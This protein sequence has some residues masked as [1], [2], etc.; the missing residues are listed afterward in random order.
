MLSLATNEIQN[1]LS[2]N[3]LQLLLQNIY[4]L[5]HSGS[6]ER[7][8]KHKE[9]D[10]LY[11]SRRRDRFRAFSS[12]LKANAVEERIDF[13]R[14]LILRVNSFLACKTFSLC[15]ISGDFRISCRSILLSSASILL[16][17]CL[18]DF[19]CTCIKTD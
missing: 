8:R 14:A 15:A 2:L 12:S 6:K 7:S 9:S 5:I 11:P 19:D 17:V 10:M 4:N 3:Q 1:N 13:L 18:Y 16:T